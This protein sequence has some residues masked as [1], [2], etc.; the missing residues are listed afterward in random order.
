MAIFIS[1]TKKNSP[2]MAS[3]AC[4]VNLDHIR[5]FQQNQHGNAVLYFDDEMTMTVEENFDSINNKIQNGPS[6]R[7]HS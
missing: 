5:S 2:G 4:M 6:T 7:T 3:T 1:V